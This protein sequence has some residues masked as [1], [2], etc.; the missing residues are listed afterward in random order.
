MPRFFLTSVEFRPDTLWAALWL[1]ALAVF[2]AGRLETWRGFA[3]GF[4]LGVDLAVSLK[5]GLCIA[6]LAVAAIAV[7]RAVPRPTTVDRRALRRFTIA[8]VLGR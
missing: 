8:A 3:G 5:T 6:A 1:A 2:L 7:A 4:L